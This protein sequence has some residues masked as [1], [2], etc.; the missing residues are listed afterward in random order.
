MIET[1]RALG[2]LAEPPLAEHER[3]AA[4]LGLPGR[5]ERAEYTRCF[6][7]QLYPYASVYLGREGMLGGEARDRIAGFWRAL[8]LVPPPEP[9][10]LATLLALY[11]NL[12]EAAAGERDALRRHAL[13]QARRALLDEHMLS[14][15]PPYLDKL[16]ELGSPLYRA[17]GRL[18]GE[19]LATEA[20]AVGAGTRLSRHLAEAPDLPGAEASL[21]ELL[22]GLLAPARSGML[23][24]RDDL[25]RAARELGLG[26]RP[27]ER[28]FVL[29]SLLGEDAP[30]TFAWLAGEA[31]RS[32]ERHGRRG[33]DRAAAHWAERARRSARWLEAL[34][35]RAQEEPARPLA[36]T[37]ET[38]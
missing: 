23:I 27:A 36:E 8:G 26:V 3:V 15:L 5:P 14:W 35:R 11:A 38:R 19:V 21:R 30:A 32:A 9:D 31:R 25:R 2:S 7:F 29:E 17:W 10:H 1:L 12:A 4:A 37:R 6:T 22:L 20:R 28:R 13:E 34:G 16:E 24:V 33:D 18:L